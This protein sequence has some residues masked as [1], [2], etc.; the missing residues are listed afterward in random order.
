M[1]RSERLPSPM[2]LQAATA[3]TRS[4]L[5]A[6]AIATPPPRAQPSSAIRSGSISSRVSRNETAARTSSTCSCGTSRPRSPSL[7]PKPR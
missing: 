7:R 4:S 2:A 1:K 5:A 6:S 3:R